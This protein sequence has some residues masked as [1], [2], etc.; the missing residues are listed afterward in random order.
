MFQ[1]WWHKSHDG[2]PDILAKEPTMVNFEKAEVK[3]EMV[4]VKSKIGE[5]MFKLQGLKTWSQEK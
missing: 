3:F 5:M 4:M 1:F 2:M